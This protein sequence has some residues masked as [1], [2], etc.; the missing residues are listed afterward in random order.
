MSAEAEEDGGQVILKTSGQIAFQ[1]KEQVEVILCLL[2]QFGW[3][4]G[5]SWVGVEMEM[6]KPI[7]AR[8]VT[9]IQVSY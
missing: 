4:V 8:L 1:L 9:T 2:S 7:L 5:S 6:L 3:L